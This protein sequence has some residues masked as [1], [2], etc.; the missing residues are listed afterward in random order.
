VDHCVL[1][2]GDNCFRLVWLV[3]N[4]NTGVEELGHPRQA[5]NSIMAIKVTGMIQVEGFH[6]H[7]AHPAHSPQ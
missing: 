3:E 6:A 1:D 7:E 2:F 4:N 5:H